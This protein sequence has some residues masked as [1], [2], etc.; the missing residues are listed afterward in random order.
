MT[1]G[2]CDQTFVPRDDLAL[3]YS[4]S[5]TIRKTTAVFRVTRV[6]KL[7]LVDVAGDVG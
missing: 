7:G 5:A 1:S 2:A 3:C 4:W 6:E